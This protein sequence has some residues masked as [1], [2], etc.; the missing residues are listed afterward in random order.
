MDAGLQQLRD[1]AG[2]VAPCT[3][4][5]T[6]A[7]DFFNHA[8]ASCCPAWLAAVVECGETL[9]G[10]I[11]ERGDGDQGFGEG[12]CLGEGHLFH[13]RNGVFAA[14]E[15]DRGHV[16]EFAQQDFD[17]GVE[18]LERHDGVGEADFVGALGV[19]QVTGEAKLVDVTG[20]DGV[21]QEHQH[22]HRED[23]DLGLGQA[24]A[25][26]GCDDR[27]VAQGHQCHAAGDAIAV[28]AADDRYAAVT[29]QAGEF[30][31][32]G[33]RIIEAEG[34]GARCRRSGRRRR[35]TPCGPP[36]SARWRGWRDRF[37]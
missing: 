37:W 19:D 34:E 6:D 7:D 22:L 29:H 24:E 5:A 33:H 9:G 16:V 26:V 4:C 28:D 32:I 27:Q 17:A 3:G 18:V 36:R 20:A 8:S 31:E 13:R 23:A 35:R 30:A 10:V 15:C 2:A 11:G 21:A 1:G 25:G 12:H 14:A